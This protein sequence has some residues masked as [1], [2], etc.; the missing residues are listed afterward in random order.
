MPRGRKPNPQNRKGYFYE[1]EEE[2]VVKY[3]TSESKEEKEQ[4][5]ND[6]LYPAFCTMAESIIRRYKLYPPDEY[7]EETFNDAVSFLMTK[8]EKFNINSN[9]K[10]YSYC[11]TIIKNYL[12]YKIN[13]YARNQKKNDS[14]EV[15]EYELSEDSKYIADDS[16]NEAYITEVINKTAGQI[17]KM[18][19]DPKK[20]DLNTNE[21][22]V[23]RALETLLRNWDEM[24]DTDGSNKF[25]RSSVSLLLK[26]MTDMSP[27]EIKD[28]SKKFKNVYYKIKDLLSD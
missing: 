8:L 13:I 10:A 9:F 26:E 17:N 12:I 11:G 1:T 24:L 21:M 22:K 7:Y 5:F 27:K 19:S 4:I 2:A 6:V 28:N 20:Y 25:N 23:G 18:I 16:F 15:R 14:F 3:L